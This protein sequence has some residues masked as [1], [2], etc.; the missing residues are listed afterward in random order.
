[1]SDGND[2]ATERSEYVAGGAIAALFVSL[3]IT[4][5]LAVY[6]FGWPS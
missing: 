3:A 5:A 6:V 1:M 2:E 4:I